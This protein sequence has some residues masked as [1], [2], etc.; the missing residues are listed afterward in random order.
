MG[1]IFSIEKR[2]QVMSRIRSKNTKAELIVFKF[3][4]SEHIYFQKHYKRAPGSPDL[5]LPRKKLAVFI[6]GDFW[7]GRTLDKLKLRR[8]DP[9][10]YWVKKITRNIQRDNEQEQ[11]LLESGWKILR[12]WESDIIKKK[13]R[14]AHLVEIANFLLS[15]DLDIVIP[16]EEDLTAKTGRR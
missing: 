15:K 9:E 10:D 16:M 1:D 4:R 14:E 11:R 13:S 2:S 7:H 5:A 6:D 8:D 3:L 12:V